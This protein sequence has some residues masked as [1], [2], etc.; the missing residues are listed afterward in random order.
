M[1]PLRR[2]APELP[3]AVWTL[4]VGGV[5]N[6]FGNGV[7]VPFLVIYLHNV[8]GFALSTAGLVLAAG[9][10]T[11][12][13]GGLAVGALVDRVGGRATL[14]AGLVIQCVAYGLLPLVREP[15]HAV[16]L[17]ALAGLGVAAFWP[18]QSTLLARLVPPQRR[19]SAYAVQRVTMNLGVG[20]GGLAG[21]LMANT[22]DAGTFTLLFLVDAAT[23]LVFAA[24]L[25]TVREPRPER[26]RRAVGTPP[27]LREVARDRPFVALLGLNVLFVAAGYAQLELLP[28]FAKNHAH[29][30]EKSIGAI[31]FVNTLVVVAGQLPVSRLLEGRRRMAA[32]AAMTVVWAFSWLVVLA[33]GATLTGPEAAATLAFAVAVFAVGEC[34][35]GPTQAALVADLAPAHL[36]GRYF[37]LSAMSWGVGNMVGPAVGGAVLGAS[38]LALWP[39]AAGVCLAAGGGA[40]LLDRRLPAAVRRTPAAAP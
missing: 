3:R 21:G 16:L 30:S 4:Q 5:A 28:A 26:E 6:S 37:S 29:V 18:G 9:A 7:V 11:S 36:S 23:F 22:R 1:M 38:P 13:A 39:L 20:L 2:V 27:P 40:L 34:F 33:G 15:W 8:R 17:T 10:V 31:F 14:T 25:A 24:V 19:H 32:L 35:Q 12:I